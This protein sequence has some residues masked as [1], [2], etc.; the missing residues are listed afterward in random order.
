MD[1]LPEVGTATREGGWLTMGWL[2]ARG[3]WF[4]A[5]NMAAGVAVNK[6][7]DLL[8]FLDYRLHVIMTM[9]HPDMESRIRLLRKRGVQI[10]ENCHLDLGV[11]IEVTTPRAVVIEDHV[12]IGPFAQILAHDAAANAMIDLPMRVRQTKIG[13]NSLVGS[14][15]TV[16]PGVT[17]GRNCG[18]MAGSIVTKDVPDG[19]VAGGNPAS[20]LLDVEDLIESWQQDIKKN[21]GAYYD[22]FNAIRSPTTPYDH[23]LWWRRDNGESIRKDTD[24]RTGTPFDMLLDAKEM[25][26][27]R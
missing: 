10:G 26:R 16:M 14:F 27:S 4:A 2:F 6:F 13:Y 5:R 22:H 23:L 21:P 1:K 11:W 7:C 18:I 8:A 24:L 15:A 19:K 25:L 20:I 17:V 12:G 3:Y 9:W